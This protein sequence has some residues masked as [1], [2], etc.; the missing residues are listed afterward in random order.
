MYVPFAWDEITALFQRWR[1]T[2]KDGERQRRAERDREQESAQR[3]MD[4]KR[5]EPNIRALDDY[6]TE[7]FAEEIG[8]HLKRLKRFLTK[9]ICFSLKNLYK[10]FDF[11]CS[12][13]LISYFIRKDSQK[14]DERFLQNT[15][16]YCGEYEPK[17][18]SYFGYI[19]KNFEQILTKIFSVCVSAVVSRIAITIG[20]I[21]M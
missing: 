18:H 12:F 21:S 5:N 10:N 2:A 7:W 4:E 19:F 9:N 16:D 20:V 6:Q 1:V 13:V 15:S 8:W 17:I 3:E 14:R 11:F